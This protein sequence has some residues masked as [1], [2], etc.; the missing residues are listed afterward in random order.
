MEPIKSRMGAIL[1]W[2]LTLVALIALADTWGYTAMDPFLGRDLEA[3]KESSTAIGLAYGSFGIA[4]TVALLLVR[5]CL[6]ESVLQQLDTQA[7][8]ERS[9]ASILCAQTTL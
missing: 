2:G 9:S 3:R 4:N 8:K 6:Y 1:R 7:V 5:S